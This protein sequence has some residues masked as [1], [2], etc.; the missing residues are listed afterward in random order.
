M[1]A[2]VRE[3]DL[4]R[5]LMVEAPR[6]GARLWRNNVGTGLAIRAKTPALR[7]AIIAE[8]QAVAA[9][10][11]GSAARITY[12][13]PTGSGD[14]IGF[15]QRDA[16]PVFASVEV[17]TKTGRE[18]EDQKRWRAYVQSVGG[19]AGAVRSVDELRALISGQKIPARGGYK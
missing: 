17:K 8:C 15:V 6:H 19:V 4:M 13:L 11:G 16:G 1:N 12:G 5:S 18:T 14:L 2:R 10:M 3:A 7:Q 9:R